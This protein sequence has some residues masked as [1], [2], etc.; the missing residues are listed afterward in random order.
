[1]S[2]IKVTKEAKKFLIEDEI[3]RWVNTS[4]LFSIRFKV[5]EKLGK[6]EDNEAVKKEMENCE[7]A[8]L[9]LEKMERELEDKK[10]T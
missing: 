7:K 10:V 5:N 9:E 4:E 2:D 3:R 6:N 8:I 1:M